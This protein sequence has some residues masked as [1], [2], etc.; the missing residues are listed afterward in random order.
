MSYHLK[1]KITPEEYEDYTV[2]TAWEAPWQKKAKRKFILNNIFFSALVMAASFIVFR[3]ISPTLKNNNLIHFIVFPFLLFI[4]VIINYSQVPYRLKSKARKFIKEDDNKHLLEELELEL[5]DKE[6]IVSNKELRSYQSW[7][8]IT[9]YAVSKKYF[10]LYVNAENAH[11]IP[12]RLLS[13]QQEIEKFDKFLT[14][15][16]PLLSSFRSLNI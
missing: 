13:T 15:K 2:F 11:L 6:I 8:S 7:T 9:K 3:Q 14:E 1:Y 10:F 5:T 4:V 12:K 16:I